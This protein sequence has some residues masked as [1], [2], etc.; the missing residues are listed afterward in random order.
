MRFA[1]ALL[2]VSL[3]A[4][5]QAA[6]SGSLRFFGSGVSA[7]TLDRVV[8]AID[9]PERPA[10]IGAG[11][12]TIEVWLRALAASN[13]AT[14][15]CGNGGDSWING[16]IFIDRDIFGEG[17]FGDYGLSL[18]RGR[19]AFGVDTLNGAATAC[20]ARD[21][22][23]GSWHH[24]AA[25]RDATSGELRVYVDGQLDGAVAGPLGD[26]SYRNGRDSVYPW[27]PFL[28]LGAEK[29]DAGANFPSFD[30]W[31]DE[32]RL[33]TLVRYNAHFSPPSSPF[34]SDA[35]TAALYSFDEGQGS[36][37]GDRSGATGGPSTGERRVGGT[38]NGPQWSAETPF[39]AAPPVDI[40]ADGFE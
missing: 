12:F 24:V 11:S 33:S 19:V 14:N 25:T 40:F 18:M 28:V 32:L 26:V 6:A 22:R 37:I 4:A 21:L 36:V 2:M 27:D 35:A 29:H 30:G 34:T 38:S 3:V 16:N 10:D 15:A 17:D 8:I 39:S 13:S 1:T 9:A 7:P 20:G 23:D 31:L 5:H